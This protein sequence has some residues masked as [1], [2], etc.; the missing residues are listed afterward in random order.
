MALS[1]HATVRCAVEVSFAPVPG[2]VAADGPPGRPG[3]THT[4]AEDEPDERGRKDTN[5]V[6]AV[7]AGVSESEEGGGDPCS[8]PEAGAFRP[9]QMQPQAWSQT[10]QGDRVNA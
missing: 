6:F 1:H 4:D 3:N 9:L 5:P 2:G 8:L 7:I 10:Q